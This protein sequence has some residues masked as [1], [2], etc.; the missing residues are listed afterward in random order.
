M[1]ERHH[2]DVSSNIRS[3]NLHKEAKNQQEFARPQ[4]ASHESSLDVKVP[5]MFV[6]DHEL[7]VIGYAL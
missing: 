3:M 7:D 4:N 2:A 6:T 1:M 5:A